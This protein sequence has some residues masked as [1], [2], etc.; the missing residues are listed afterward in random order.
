MWMQRAAAACQS[1][2]TE[3]D[4]LAARPP[5]TLAPVPGGRL[6]AGMKFELAAVVRVGVTTEL[7]RSRSNRP[8]WFHF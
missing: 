3:A 5:T 7:F 6:Q 8:L 1:C 2:H 4:C